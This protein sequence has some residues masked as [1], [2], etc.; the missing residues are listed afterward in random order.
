MIVVRSRRV[1][2]AWVV[3]LAV[4]V[5]LVVWWLDGRD[6]DDTRSASAAQGAAPTSSAPRDNGV[7]NGDGTEVIRRP[8][9][10]GASGQ[11]GL[12]PTE[13]VS[14]GSLVKTPL[15]QTASREGA[16]VAG[17]PASVVPVLPGSAVDSSG[18]SSSRD[19]VQVSIVASSPRSRDAV[20]AFYR[21]QLGA[22]GFAESVVPGSAGSVGAGFMRGTDHLVVTTTAAGQKTSYSL[23]GTLHARAHD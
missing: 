23:F 21:R 9:G 15:P 13:S 3:A 4:V 7:T 8:E 12:R 19:A 6:A 17:F 10:S 11:A 18:V 5:A 1:P 22:Q 16:L 14:T 2:A 20:L